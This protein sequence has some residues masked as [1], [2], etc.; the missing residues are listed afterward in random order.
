MLSGISFIF[1]LKISECIGAAYLIGIIPYLKKTLVFLRKYKVILFISAALLLPL[2][3]FIFKQYFLSTRYTVTLSLI[4]LIPISYTFYNAL[5]INNNKTIKLL[6]SFL[7]LYSFIDGVF[8]FNPTDKSYFIT[9]SDWI[10]DNQSSHQK[11]ITNDNRLNFLINH[12]YAKAPTFH[13]E[14]IH[15]TD[16]EYLVLFIDKN[17]DNTDSIILKSGLWRKEENFKNNKNDQITIYKRTG[18]I[19]Q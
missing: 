19:I 4:L 18:Q 8:S 16:A 3:G 2:V 15:S 13:L 1:L 17:D 7:L 6:F 9:A 11:T 10:K 14:S 12:K 5:F